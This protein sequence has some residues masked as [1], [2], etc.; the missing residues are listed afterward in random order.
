MRR[1]PEEQV[2][3]RMRAEN[4]WWDSARIRDDYASMKRR[5]YFER[6]E[7]LVAQTDVRR[8][9]VLMGPRRVGKTVLLHYAR[10]RIGKAEGE[11]DIVHLNKMQTPTWCLDVKWSDRPGRHPEELTSLAAFA[12]RHPRATTLVTTRTLLQP[13]LHWP[14][15]GS[16]H[17]VPTSLYCYAVGRDVIRDPSSVPIWGAI[18]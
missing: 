1:V 7:Q 13:V 9:V 6:F 8:A 11:V 15:P 4:P 14:G 2:R 12:S 17:A 16:L 5:A 18:D 3:N 10:W